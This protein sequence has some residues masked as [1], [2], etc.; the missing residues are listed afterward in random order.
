MSSTCLSLNL[1]FLLT[2][3][4]AVVLQL[5]SRLLVVRGKPSEAIPRLLAEWSINRLTFESDTEPYAT[6]RDKEV[7]GAA[8]AAGVQVRPNTE[9]LNRLGRG[10]AAFIKK[11]FQR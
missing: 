11:A 5:G 9:E 4:W 6:V 3:P 10:A 7:C 2:V 8:K 1:L